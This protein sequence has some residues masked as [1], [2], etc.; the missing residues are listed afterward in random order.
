MRDFTQGPITKQVVAFSLPLL[1][2]NLLQT[3]GSVITTVFIGKILGEESLAA[4]TSCMP[5]LFL[6]ISLLMGVAIATNILIAQAYG[7]KEMGLVKKVM[8]NS[9]L[10]SIGLCILITAFSLIF[11]DKILELFRTP[12]DVKPL[13]VLFFRIIAGGLLIQFMY[14]WFSGLLRGLGNSKI[15]LYILILSTALTLILVPFFIIVLK[16]GI[17]G[18]ALGAILANLA[19]MIWGYFYSI[20]KYPMFDMTKWDYKPD[21][22]ILKKIVVV[23]F[24]AT[25]QMMVTS[26]AGA[27]ILGLVNSFGNKD[28]T[29]AFGAGMQADQIAFLP[30]MTLG[31]AISSMIGQNLA[32]G[33]FDRIKKFLYSALIISVS[34]SAVLNILIFIFADTL[35]YMFNNKAETVALSAHYF[36]IISFTYVAYS[37]MFAFQGV[38]RGAGDTM[39]S[40]IITAIAV[41][42]F[43]MPLSWYLSQHTSLAENGIWWGM[44]FSTFIGVILSW[45]YYLLGRWKKMRLV[46]RS[47]PEKTEAEADTLSNP[48]FME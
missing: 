41:I 37:L 10:A 30:A 8:S 35:G 15:P 5:I 7:I 47:K 48:Q 25:M 9:F 13:A 38:I 39:A 36:R 19:G 22:T 14:N 27:L 40:L 23:G 24:P 45:G 33:K 46:E 42:G 12:P 21:W 1:L 11:A 28:L 17:A 4:A 2:G 32:A 16:I 3:L 18:A 26:F 34:I 6:F 31:M 43:R 20:K 44:L 29:A